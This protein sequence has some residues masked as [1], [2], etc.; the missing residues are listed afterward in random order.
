[1]PTVPATPK[2]VSKVADLNKPATVQISEFQGITYAAIRYMYE[3]ED[4][5]LAF[6]KN[7]INIPIEWLPN[8]IAELLEVY[9]QSTGSTLSLT[10]ENTIKDPMLEQP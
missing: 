3:K 1:M 10:G 7:G 9:N 6:G 8:A 5:S 4:G 2:L